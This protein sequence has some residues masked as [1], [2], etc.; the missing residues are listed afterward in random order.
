MKLVN[1]ENGVSVPDKNGK[2]VTLHSECFRTWLNAQVENEL[3]PNFQPANQPL[4]ISGRSKLIRLFIGEPRR[5]L[6]YLR[7]LPILRRHHPQTRS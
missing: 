4:P 5:T 6:E 3:T 2:P 7:H 1:A